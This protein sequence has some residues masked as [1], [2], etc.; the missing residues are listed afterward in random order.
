MINEL[1]LS[2]NGY[3][4]SLPFLAFIVAVGCIITTSLRFIQIRT[5]CKGW[6]LILLGDGTSAADTK[7]DMSPFQAFLNTLSVS[8]GNGSLAGIAVAIAAGGPGA[9]FW[10]FIVGLL[11]MAIRCAEVFLGVSFSTLAGNKDRLGG[12]FLYIEKLPGG[13]ILAYLY[14]IFCLFFGFTGGNA[15]QCNSISTAFCRMTGSPTW[16][17]A[18]ALGLFVLYVMLGGSKRIVKVV[19]RVV[20][21]KVGLFFITI[22]IVLAYYW[23][24]LPAAVLFIIKSAFNPQAAYG[25]AAGLTLPVMFAAATKVTINASE[26]GLGTA[27]IFY[28]NTGSTNPEND[29]ITS[30]LST[31]LSNNVAGMMV[32]IALVASGVWNK[33]SD[34]APMVIEAYQTVFGH[35]GG[36][37]V[38]FL[39]IPFGIGV[40]ISYGYVSRQCWLY[41]TNKRWSGIFPYI[42]ATTSCLGAIAPIQVVWN[43]LYIALAALLIINLSALVYYIP[44]MRKQIFKK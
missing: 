23:S 18:A 40:F 9:A 21:L 12:P 22:L 24:A 2:I 15:M 8:I 1:I 44:Y 28:G 26:A 41:L 37:I 16:I 39:T 32:A 33:G 7:G 43:A 14:G 19:E 34:G 5:F 20:P 30:M 25:A 11:S 38:T 35:W 27:A 13:A 42:F 29:G 10:I 36:W 4:W 3:L 17:V 6:K 31:F